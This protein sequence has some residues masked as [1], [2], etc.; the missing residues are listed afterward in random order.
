MALEE[1]ARQLRLAVPSRESLVRMLKGWERGD[2]EPSDFYRSL[3]ALVYGVPERSL[4]AELS[5]SALSVL[6]LGLVAVEA[7][8]EAGGGSMRRRD[9]LLSGSVLGSLA[10]VGPAQQFRVGMA[11]AREV[12]AAARSLHRWDRQMGGWVP[13]QAAIGYVDTAMRLVRGTY[14]EKVAHQLLPAVADLC[15][16]TGWVAYDVGQT[17][18]ALRYFSLGVQVA[19]QA[20]DPALAA[21][22]LCDMARVNADLGN[23]MHSIELL[24]LARHLSRSQVTATVLA[25]LHSMEAKTY[26]ILGHSRECQQAIGQASQRIADGRSERDPGWIGYFNESQFAGVVGS[27]YRDLARVDSRFA[28]KAEDVI[29]RATTA[30]SL[31]QIR[32]RALDHVNLATARL[33][34]GELD[35][36]A[37][38]ATEAVRLAARLKSDRVNGR[39]R[40]LA[41]EAAAAAK[42]HQATRALLDQVATLAVIGS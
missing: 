24:G 39:L 21:R 4:F 22:L 8:S 33:R 19:Q 37:E 3:W 30:R 11:E 5:P 36:M 32:N 17:Q 1:K 41:G 2:H 7:D 23:P 42:G 26:A 18:E 9:V 27:C 40:Q 28:L 35:G 38:E 15:A 10:F 34:R 12:A 14:T 29:Q 31:D 25:K 13:Y 6:G 16:V 20:Q